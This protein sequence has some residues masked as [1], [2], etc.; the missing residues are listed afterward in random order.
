[1]RRLEREKER[2]EHENEKLREKLTERDKKLVEAEKQIADLERQLGL[3][4]RN[5]TTSSKPPSS[6]GLAGEQRERGS[7]RKKSCRKPG[8]QPGQ[9][10][11]WRR[12]GLRH[13]VT[14]LPPI[15]P[16]I[17]EYRCHRIW[18]PE[19]GKETQAP[20]PPEVAGD[21]G[22]N[23][24]A[25]IAYLTVVCRMPRRV[26]L[27]LLEQGLGIRLSLGSVQSSWDK[28]LRTGPAPPIF[29]GSVKSQRSVDFLV[30]SNAR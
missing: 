22:P 1:M 19:Y 12:P 11:H 17:T 25:L 28:V 8:G 26:V 9:P 15:Q 14:E 29:R 10:G 27:A 4:K 24:T 5:S 18:S 20:L 13:Q 16:Q 3:Q 21:F 7:R 30:S 2:L 6:D 23:L